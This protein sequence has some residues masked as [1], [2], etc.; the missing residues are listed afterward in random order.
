[1]RILILGGTVFL[2]RHVADEALARGHELTLYTRG[3]HG[4]VP[5]GVEHVLGDRAD[6]TPLHGRSWD[7][8]I[9]TSGYDPAHVAAV[10]GA[11]R[12]P[13]RVRLLL[14]R[15]PRLARRAGRR[16]LADVDRTARATGR[17]R[18][19]RSAPCSRA[20]RSCARG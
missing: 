17:T 7:A 2:G 16:G 11:G 1:M 8:V 19:R 15:L 4:S 18:R 5:D 9:D 3:R 20:A 6:L 13:L 12:R 14:Q 10:G